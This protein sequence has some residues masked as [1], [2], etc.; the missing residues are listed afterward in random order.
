MPPRALALPFTAIVAALITGLV[1]APSAR[2]TAP[3]GDGR[4]AFYGN[5]QSGTAVGIYTVRPDGTGLRRLT[6][7]ADAEPA[8][9]PTGAESRSSATVTSG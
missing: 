1:A 4:I 5:G 2:A 3:G 6:A 9:A 7:A 8:W